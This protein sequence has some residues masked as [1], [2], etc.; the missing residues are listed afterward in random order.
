[1]AGPMPRCLRF[2]AAD[3]GRPRP[4]PV[5]TDGRE[6]VYQAKKFGLFVETKSYAEKK[7]PA[8][9]TYPEPKLLR[10]DDCFPLWGCRHIIAI[11]L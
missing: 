1:M 4:N 10:K 11:R 3:V 6:R 9:S 8:Y 7:T 5:R 2:F